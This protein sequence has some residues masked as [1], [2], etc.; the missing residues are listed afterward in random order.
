VLLK[1]ESESQ[2]IQKDIQLDLEVNAEGTPPM[3]F[4]WYKDGDS[5]PLADKPLLRLLHTD[6]NHEG[7][8]QC[9]ISNVCGEK[10]T[11]PAILYVAPEICMVTIDT[12]TGNN[13]IIWEKQSSAPIVSY[14]IYREGVIA[15]LYDMIG[16]VPYNDLSVFVDTA[17]N[18]EVQAYWYK[19]AAVDT[20]GYESDVDLCAPH[21]TIHLLVTLNP[22]TGAT[23]LDWDR[24]IGFE[25]GTFHILRSTQES[26]FSIYHSMAS[27]T[28]TW[29]DLN[30]E[31]AVYYYRVAVEKSGLCSPTGSLKAESGPYS[32]SMSNMEDNRLQ[33]GEENNSP[34]L[35][36]IIDTTI[37]ENQIVGSFIGKLQTD[38]ADTLDVHTYTLVSGTGSDDN[39]KFTILGDLLLSAQIFD[40]ETKSSYSIR[41]R[42]TDN[43]TGNLHT[44]QVFHIAVLDA[45]ETGINNAPTGITITSD[46]IEEN[47]LPGTLVGRFETTDPDVGDVH[48]YAL[49]QGTGSDDNS[50]FSIMGN[51]LIAAQTFDYETKQQYYIRIRSTDNGTGN[52]YTEMAFTINIIDTDET[53]VNNT[54]TDISLDNNLI[55]ENKPVGTFIG[56]FQTT[57]PDELDTHI[58]SLVPGTGSDDNSSFTI[59]G[60]LLL[61]AG[62]FDYELKDT[63][64]IRIRSLDNGES[65][66]Y[67]EK[68][69]III[70]NDLLETGIDD[71][72]EKTMLIYPNPFTNTTNILFPNPESSEYTLI[73]RNLSG[74]TVRI[75]D[76][77]T[78]SRYMLNKEDLANGYYLIELRGDKIYRGRFVIE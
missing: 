44:E 17:A 45:S 36:T 71:V 2:W 61:S 37:Y 10:E 55:D 14:N 54:P 27:S 51:L 48:T 47:H 9:K 43:G 63:L 8:Y 56:R 3:R 77:I 58:Y 5:I 65:R 41:V 20:G 73:I 31:Q 13:L 15:D 39:M 62:T 19:I 30:P 67:L 72:K 23:Q 64:H 74:R 60:D 53:Q 12:A 46:T 25:Y 66:L 11:T 32:H 57:D 42:S 34:T 1:T 26:G 76:N 4:Q 75:I 33:A 16:T 35:I 38:D 50:S 49:V 7:E 78:S 68:T 24:Y 6:Y 70:V 21:K 69:F 28:T 22:E 18:P 52:L 40:Y 59:L 29:S